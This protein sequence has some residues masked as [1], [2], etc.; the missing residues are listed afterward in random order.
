MKNKLKAI[1]IIT[2]FTVNLL[3]Q[4]NKVKIDIIKNSGDYYWG[5]A[6]AES[7]DRAQ[8]LAYDRLTKM[9]AVKVSSTFENIITER[10]DDLNQ[11]VKQIIKTYSISTFKNVDR[12]QWPTDDGYYLFL[13]LKK[14]E[15]QKIT[16]ERKKLIYNIYE[17][18][19]QLEKNNDYAYALKSYYF[20]T[21]LMASI[22]EQIITYNDV[23]LTTAIPA[24]IN[25]II[26]NT[27]FMLTLNLKLTNKEREI[28]LKVLVG[29]KPAKSMEFS[30]WD[31]NNQQNVNTRDG[32]AIIRLYGASVNFD[33]LDVR[34]K[35]K[36]YECRS[37]I[38]AVD[39]LWDLVKLPSFKN[40]KKIDLNKPAEPKIAKI[41]HPKR[42]VDNQL[43]DYTSSTFKIKIN[44][45]ENSLVTDKIGKEVLILLQ[46]ID[47]HNI[48]GIRKRYAKDPYIVKKLEAILKYNDIS[49]VDK[50]IEAD[51]NKFFNGWEVRE[52][53][54]FTDYSS[55]RKQT[56]ESLIID[57]DKDGNLYDINFGILESLYDSFRELGNRNGDWQN[58]QVI[59]KFTEKYRTAF[60][61]RDMDMLDSLFAEEAI[62]IVGRKLK[63]NKMKDVS[64]INAQLPEIEYLRMNK[65]QYLKRQKQIF[66]SRKDIYIG[67]STFKITRKN[68]QPN[69]YGVSM[70]QNYQSTG[71]ADEGYL[72]LLVDF[73]EQLPQIYV[74]SW[75]PQEWDDRELI[76]L[77]SFNLNK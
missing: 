71:Y 5:E 10:G 22:P 32:E 25:G 6:T 58:R 66:N 77:S 51:L 72:F 55:I 49:V 40:K 27:R 14:S 63:K 7:I 64:Q 54:V 11:T 45:R 21:V 74:R 50:E 68:K 43:Q 30:F 18:A 8:D 36:F 65:K 13:Y 19:Q 1:V 52:V 73:N 9:I 12:Y 60:L 3:A 33:K 23:N 29:N 53:R 42:T 57:F 17:N 37:E 28:R 44:N 24:R 15:V 56:T 35:Y 62:I 69:V 31:G 38:K 59:I 46:L 75:Q 70:R 47:D 76:K 34:I 67:Y 61:T 16:E 39:E 41:E 2:L 26:A 20:A 4:S 48:Q